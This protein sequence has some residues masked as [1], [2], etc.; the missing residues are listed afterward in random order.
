MSNLLD[1]PQFTM[2]K[3]FGYL[4]VRDILNLR[5]T[6]SHIFEVSRD[7]VFYER[8]QIYVANIKEVDLEL[9]GRLGK[10]LHPMQDITFKAA[11]KNN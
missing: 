5:A 10:N 8:V 1:V 11:L 6:C 2:Q 9:Y 4:P 3:L 7:R